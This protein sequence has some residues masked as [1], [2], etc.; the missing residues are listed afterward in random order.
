M[1]SSSVAQL[2]IVDLLHLYEKGL[3]ETRDTAGK[4]G[5]LRGGVRTAKYLDRYLLSDGLDIDAIVAEATN[6]DIEGMLPYW[7]K[8]G[9]SFDLSWLDESEVDEELRSKTLAGELD[10]SV[11]AAA[12][13]LGSVWSSTH[14]TIASSAQ[15]K[16]SVASIRLSLANTI[17]SLVAI[18]VAVISIVVACSSQ[19]SAPQIA[20]PAPVLLSPTTISKP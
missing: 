19:S 11:R 12:D 10:E 20:P 17:L 3:N 5:K 7:L 16:Q 9:M 15:L 1:F 6:Y 4:R 13:R 14:Q 18:F 2:A 8:G